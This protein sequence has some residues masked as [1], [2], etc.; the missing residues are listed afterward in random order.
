M[1]NEVEDIE[2]LMGAVDILP[3]DTARVLRLHYMGKL[4]LKEICFIMGKSISIIHNHR[5]RG[6]F[7]LRKHF[8]KN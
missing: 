2:K 1:I 7:L 3:A 8:E 4:S 5:K 6:L